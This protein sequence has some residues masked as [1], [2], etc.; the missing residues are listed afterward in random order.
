MLKYLVKLD[1]ATIEDMC[2][3]PN[4]ALMF[5]TLIRNGF[6]IFSDHLLFS[7]ATLLILFDNVSS[8]IRRNFLASK[9]RKQSQILDTCL[10]SGFLTNKLELASRS[11]YLC[12]GLS[13]EVNVSRT[14][15]ASS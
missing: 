9:G 5:S 14:L 7:T 11:L 6:I 4:I 1:S 8:E 13:P 2:N 3:F 15:S 10:V 12:K